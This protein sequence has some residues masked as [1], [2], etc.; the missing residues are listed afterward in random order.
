MMLSNYIYSEISLRERNTGRCAHRCCNSRVGQSSLSKRLRP[1]DVRLSK[2]HRRGGGYVLRDRLFNR[3]DRRR[4]ENI[5]PENRQGS[6]SKQQGR[7]GPQ[8]QGADG[9]PVPGIP[10]YHGLKPLSFQI[11]VK[12]TPEIC[13]RLLISLETEQA[14]QADRCIFLWG[15]IQF[16][17]FSFSNS[18]EGDVGVVALHNAVGIERFLRKL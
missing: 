17:K 11:S 14:L 13:V 2:F 3:C 12:A 5:D 6:S 10:L 8:N 4:L 15:T 7:V 18:L 1:S 9:A 16:H